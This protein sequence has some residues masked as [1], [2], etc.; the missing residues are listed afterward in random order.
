M[1]RLAYSIA[2]VLLI[3]GIHAQRDSLKKIRL[4]GI[5]LDLGP[6]LFAEFKQREQADYQRYVKNDPI[7]NDDLSNY[8]RQPYYFLFNSFDALVG[9]KTYMDI[10][11]GKKFRKELF[12]GLKYGQEYGSGAYYNGALYDTIGTYTDGASGNKV[13]E[14]AKQEISYSF[15]TRAQKLILP[16]GINFTTDKKR[17][18]WIT[19][20]IELA[21]A[22]NFK[23]E[24]I[25]RKQVSHYTV[26]VREGD[27]L[28]SNNNYTSSRINANV[29]TE[30]RKT[31]LGGIGY[32][33]YASLPFSVYLHP[34]KR[35]AFLKH[36]NLLV[37]VAPT[38]MYSYSKYTGAYSGVTMSMAC[39]L[40]YNW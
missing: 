15:D 14:L 38:Y 29:R 18:F 40:R 13:Y 1:K 17:V 36:M 9:G 8:K 7:L 23:Y 30:S 37:S 33:F 2:G 26:F 19:A 10:N 4:S 6:A 21:P 3:T 5:Q 27:T 31:Q 34:F 24:F 35:A 32:G 28:N 20:G 11:D 16:F 12:I 22:L 39:G 25:S